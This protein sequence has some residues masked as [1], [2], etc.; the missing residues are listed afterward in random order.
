MTVT[1]TDVEKGKGGELSGS[2]AG[3]AAPDLDDV[4]VL[5]GSGPAEIIAQKKRREAEAEAAEAEDSKPV[6]SNAVAIE[7]RSADI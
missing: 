4:A 7:V 5:G 3:G 1:K 2:F 6:D